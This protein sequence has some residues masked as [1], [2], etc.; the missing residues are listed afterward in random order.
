MIS[1]FFNIMNK[2]IALFGDLLGAFLIALLLGAVCWVACIYYARLWH[3]RFYMKPKHHLLCAIA[4]IFTVI[5]TV[6]YRAVGYLER[7]VNGVI[8]H[9]S[10]SI[11]DDQNFHD[12]TYEKAYY[13]VK[14]EFPGD[15][16]GVPEPN[17]KDTYIPAKSNEMVQLCAQVFVEET[18]SAFFTRHPFLNFMLRARPGI[19]EEKIRTDIKEF[20]QKNPGST[21]PLSSAVEI[22]VEHIR[23]GLLKQSPKTVWKTRLILVILFVMAQAIPFGVIG[24]VAY[25]DI[26]IN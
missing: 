11:V 22:A 14:E 21:Y 3:K 2:C 4:A 1:D 9:W 8:D 19:S 15:F 25:K 18:C 5:F 6:Q 17:D 26:R 23:E 10:T 13:T 7:I 20:F 16:S 12:E 24:Y